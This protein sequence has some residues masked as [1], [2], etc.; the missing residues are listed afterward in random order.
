MSH[1]SMKSWKMLCAIRFELVQTRFPGERPIEVLFVYRQVSFLSGEPLDVQNRE[2]NDV[3]SIGVSRPELP[4]WDDLQ[5][6]TAQLA[7]APLDDVTHVETS[8]T[9]GPAADAPLE[10][11][12]PVFGSDM[13]V[14]ALSEEAKIALSMVAE[15]AGT[16]ICSGEGGMLP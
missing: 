14:A 15:R 4:S 13:S 16:G 11:D 3:S 9:I 7:R 6:F 12:I 10:L 1:G 2:R 5:I 8:L